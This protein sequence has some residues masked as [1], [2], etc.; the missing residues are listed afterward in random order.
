MSRKVASRGM[1]AGVTSSDLITVFTCACAESRGVAFMVGFSSWPDPRGM[2]CWRPFSFLLRTSVQVYGQAKLT[3]PRHRSEACLLVP[4]EEDPGVPCI[5]LSGKSWHCVRVR[6]AS[7]RFIPTGEFYLFVVSGK[8]GEPT[9][10]RTVL[11]AGTYPCVNTRGPCP[12]ELGIYQG[13]ECSQRTT[14]TCN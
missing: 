5:L 8:C 7:T 12:P 6:E 9:R 14:Q 13:G 10:A 4:N 3:D 1:A 2:V 11:G